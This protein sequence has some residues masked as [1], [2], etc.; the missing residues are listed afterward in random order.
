MSKYLLWC[1]IVVAVFGTALMG[2]GLLMIDVPD[3]AQFFSIGAPLV[4]VSVV[5]VAIWAV[6]F[7]REGGRF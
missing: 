3:G 6:I 1:G 7:W 5:L 2:Y 4:V